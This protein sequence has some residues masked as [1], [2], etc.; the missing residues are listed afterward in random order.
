MLREIEIAADQ[1][2]RV[3]PRAARGRGNNA[4]LNRRVTVE[5]NTRDTEFFL[6][7]PSRHTEKTTRNF[8]GDA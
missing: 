3:R 7:C 6:L 5:V 8:V 2:D 4:T 1:R